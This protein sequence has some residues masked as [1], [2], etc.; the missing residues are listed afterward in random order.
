[1]R[2]SKLEGLKPHFATMAATLR[3]QIAEHVSKHAIPYNAFFTVDTG[4]NE[5]RDD[6]PVPHDWD[7]FV[8]SLTRPRRWI[9]AC[10]CGVLQPNS[11]SV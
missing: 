5:T 9:V 11:V 4:S 7:T 8:A 10:P 2:G 6:G 3:A 1:M